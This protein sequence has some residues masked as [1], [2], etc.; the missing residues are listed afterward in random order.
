MYR[1]I[2][3]EI[4]FIIMSQNV[5]CPNDEQSIRCFFPTQNCTYSHFEDLIQ[6]KKDIFQRISHFF[7]LLD[8]N[9]CVGFVLSFSVN[10]I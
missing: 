7:K 5:D 9:R 6:I 2:T 1:S 4:N 10:K 3:L 8:R